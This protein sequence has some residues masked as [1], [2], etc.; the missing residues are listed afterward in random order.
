MLNEPVVAV[1]KGNGVIRLR[2]LP[3]GLH[4]EQE[5]LVAIL[6][7]PVKHEV[8]DKTR[9]TPLTYFRALVSQLHHY[10]KK[11]NMSSEEFYEGFQS[12]AIQEGPFDYFDWRTLY[13]GYRQMQERFHFSR[14]P[15]ADV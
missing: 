1:Y 3:E 4:K 9:P 8:T 7:I 15:L 5:L 14:G 2:Q 13:D 10:E 11:Y 12:G 6:P